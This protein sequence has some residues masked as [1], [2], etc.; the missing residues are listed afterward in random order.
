MAVQYV[1]DEEMYQSP[2]DGQKYERVD[3][4]MRVGPGGFWHS[5]VTVNLGARLGLFVRQKN[6]TWSQ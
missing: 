1:T 3:G 6:L 5:A 4:E 2:R